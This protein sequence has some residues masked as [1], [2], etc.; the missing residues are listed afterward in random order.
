MELV[1]NIAN[2]SISNRSWYSLLLPEM[3][4]MKK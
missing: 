3:H 1:V 4:T 2:I